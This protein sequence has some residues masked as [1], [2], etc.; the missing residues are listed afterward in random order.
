M[1][2]RLLILG[3]LVVVLVVMAGLNA[4]SYVQKI[5][6][7]DSEIF[8]NRSTFHPG[9]TGLLAYY[10]LLAET[11]RPVSRWQQPMSELLSNSGEKPA[12][13]IMAG[14]FRKELTEDEKRELLEWVGRGGR[15]VIIDREPAAE[16]IKTTS[17]WSISSMSSANIDLLSVDPADQKQM[18]TGVT[19][20]APDQ[21]TILTT[22]VNAIQPSRYA[23]SLLLAHLQPNAGESHD[24]GHY[25]DDSGDDIYQDEELD[26]YYNGQ[27][28]VQPTATPHDFFGDPDPQDPPPP[29]ASPTV[30][31]EQTPQETVA[32]ETVE[33]E[34]EPSF[35]APV[36]HIS[37]GDRVFLAEAPYGMGRIVFLTD[38]FIVANGG[39][40]MT[41]NSRLAINLAG[42]GPTVFDEYH[43]G[44]GSGNN[45]LFEYFAGT[46]VI[47]I[48]FQL[49][50]VIALVMYSRSRRFARAVPDPDPD[51]LSKL[52]Y[53]AA[54]AELQQKTKAY[55]LAME[56][57]YY[58]LR[59][60]AARMLGVDGTTVKPEEL[61]ALIS[62]RS[63]LTK[64]E[65][66]AKINKCQEIIHGE[67]TNKNEMLRLTA[68]LR[69]V[70]EK[71]RLKRHR[72]TR[73]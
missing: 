68:W 40:S 60:R 22:G 62:E 34:Y 48:L 69:D 14:P 11:G 31:V 43:H 3:G 46:P 1:K 44:Y 63:G 23:S 26:E 32:E 37:D 9:A 58:D 72:K 6:E 66:L 52:E 27:E 41:D 16:L 10:T 13:F 29:S 49:V 30:A 54:M 50:L 15:L 24:D 12:T 65:V 7:P 67:P 38:P 61:A 28:N 70:E 57:I 18:T 8:P 56:N 21:P 36:V 64:A 73:I 4:A 39:I 53:I 71:L 25:I 20:A 5:K 17:D 2:E 51:R 42:A 47:A 35:S 45:R 19:A 33:E 55:D 59:R